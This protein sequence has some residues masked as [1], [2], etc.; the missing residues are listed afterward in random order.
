M[1][2]NVEVLDT[3]PLGVS[4]VADGIAVDPG[5]GTCATVQAPTGNQE[6][7]CNLGDLDVGE[8]QTITIEVLVDQNLPDGTVLF[9]R[10]E[11]TSDN[12]DPDNSDN[13]ATES[14]T[15]AARAGP[16]GG[17]G[18]R[19]GDR[20]GRHAA[21]VHDHRLQHG[22]SEAHNVIVTD[23]L[24][25]GVTFL[26]AQVAGGCGTCANLPAGTRDVPAAAAAGGRV[27]RDHGQRDGGAGSGAV[28][29]RPCA[30]T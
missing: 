13:I 1:A 12:F 19:P 6:V 4:V 30:T 5:P 2:R 26:D 25:F 14:T 18:R 28:R 29:H 10:A 23:D 22:S 20:D 3:L 11:V 27:R 24:P 15:V 9:N 7:Q 21:R 8:T 16:V 17:Q